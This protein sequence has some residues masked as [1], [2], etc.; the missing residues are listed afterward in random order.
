MMSI[1][2]SK[3]FP[4][5]QNLSD[6]IVFSNYRDRNFGA[7]DYDVN[8]F[9]QY[10]MQKC[11]VKRIP[12]NELLILIQ[13]FLRAQKRELSYSYM[14]CKQFFVLSVPLLQSV[15]LPLAPFPLWY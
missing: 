4:Y 8:K 2:R 6:K 7:Y 9:L 5:T 13:N 15:F 10:W 11:T 14:F 1:F 12:K 3:Y